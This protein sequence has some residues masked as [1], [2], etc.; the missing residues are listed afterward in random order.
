MT[1]G[2]HV[3]LKLRD[4]ALSLTGKRHSEEQRNVIGH[5]KE[6]PPSLGR[7]AYRGAPRGAGP[8]R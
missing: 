8:L 4:P 3:M 1:L 5:P 2:V 6:R 7:C